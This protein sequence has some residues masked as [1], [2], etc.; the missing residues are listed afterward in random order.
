MKGEPCHQVSAPIAVV[1]VTPSRRLARDPLKAGPGRQ[2]AG[3][4]E[5][6]SIGGPWVIF[7]KSFEK[8]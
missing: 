6:A 3:S 5:G 4:K 8:T 2:D 7:L 1:F